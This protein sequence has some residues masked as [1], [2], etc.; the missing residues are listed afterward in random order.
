LVYPPPLVIGDGGDE[1]KNM[2]EEGALSLL[3]VCPSQVAEG[4][5]ATVDELTKRIE[6][7]ARLH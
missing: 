6:D 4:V 1:A 5:P 3:S 7:L 2:P